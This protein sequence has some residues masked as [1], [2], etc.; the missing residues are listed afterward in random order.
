MRLVVLSD[1]HAFHERIAVPD[2]DVVAHAGDFSM[3]GTPRE[4]EPFVA[5]FRALPHAH[6]VLVAGNHDWLFEREPAKARRLLEGIVYLEDSGTVLEGRS[7]YGSPWQPR[8]FDWAFNL[9][10]GP[11][12]AAK[13]ALIPPGT[14]ILITHGPPHGVLDEAR[15]EHVGDEDLLRR[16]AQL[17][18]RVHL[19][20]HIHEGYGRLERDG[21]TFVNASICTA[22]YEPRNV[23]IV[24]DV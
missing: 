21:T 22:R 11:A 10:R 4:I 16:V 8:F 5:W 6:K 17:A 18:P 2:G 19:F 12:L 13:W 24:L 3:H 9:D 14:E 20:G 23:P 1:T 15:G 7:F